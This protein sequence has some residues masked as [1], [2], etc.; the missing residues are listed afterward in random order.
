VID[1]HQHLGGGGRTVEHLLAHQDA[2]GVR[3]AV[4]L[5]IDRSLAE[6][7][8][9]AGHVPTEHALAAARAHPDRA[10]PICHVDPR[11]PDALDR[12]RRS[13]AAGARG[14]GAPGAGRARGRALLTG[15]SDGCVERQTGLVVASGCASSRA[16]ACA[17]RRRSPYACLATTSPAK[18]W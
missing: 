7:N 11:H 2:H 5:P 1:L 16:R 14:Y 8:D 12:V 4:V 10:I 6:G 9:R 17:G 18:H 13:H 3:Q 15:R